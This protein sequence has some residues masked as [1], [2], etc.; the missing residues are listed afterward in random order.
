MAIG[1]KTERRSGGATLRMLVILGFL[2]AGGGGGSSSSTPAPLAPARGVLKWGTPAA[3]GPAKV[4]LS[5][6]L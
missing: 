5:Q 6:V 3:G 2:A 1:K 4:A